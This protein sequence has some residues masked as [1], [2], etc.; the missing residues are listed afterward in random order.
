MAL[1]QDLIVTL[2][3]AGALAL[4]A[5]RVFGFA[6]ANAGAAPKCAGCESSACAP[7]PVSTASDAGRPATHPLVFVRAKQ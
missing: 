6:R 7:A 3:A 5:R 2:V 1:A 4:V